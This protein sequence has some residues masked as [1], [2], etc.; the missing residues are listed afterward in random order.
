MLSSRRLELREA[1]DELFRAAAGK[2]HGKPP[3][4]IVSFDG[5]DGAHAKSWVADFLPEEW[6]RASTLSRRT[7]RV[8]SP[9]PPRRLRAKA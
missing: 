7:V 3:V 6:I 4:F 1:L 9:A 2:A 5:D 8:V